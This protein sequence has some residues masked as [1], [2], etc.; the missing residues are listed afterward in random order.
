MED[1]DI[2]YM[3]LY[4]RELESG[5]GM[6]LVESDSEPYFSGSR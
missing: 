1:H 4:L 5:S 2:A 6:L 3:K